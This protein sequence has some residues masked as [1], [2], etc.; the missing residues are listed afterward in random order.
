MKS[1][2]IRRFIGLAT[3]CVPDERDLPSVRGRITPLAAGSLFPNALRELK[4]MTE[5]VTG[6]GLDWTLARIRRPINKPSR[7]RVRAGFLGRDKVGSSMTRQD[8]A[9]FMVDQL[10]ESK[11]VGAAPAISN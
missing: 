10:H 8:I 3:P 11:F 5:A 1:A 4:G 7:R 9:R 6:S 2:G